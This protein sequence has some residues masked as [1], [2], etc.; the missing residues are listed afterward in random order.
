M[1]CYAVVLENSKVAGLLVGRN[2]FPF[3]NTDVTPSLIANCYA[4][5]KDYHTEEAIELVG[6]NKPDGVVLNSLWDAEKCGLSE[7]IE[8]GIPRSTAEM[9]DAQ[10]YLSQGWDFVGEQE[11]GVY[12]IWSMPETDG[13][14]ILA[15]VYMFEGRG[16][17]RDPYLVSTAV[18]L[19]AV[20]YNPQACY[21][22]ASSIDLAGIPWRSA[23]I[24][25]FAGRFYGNGHV[26]SNL[27]IR[28]TDS[29]KHYYDRDSVGLVGQLEWGAEILDLGVVDVNISAVGGNVG[30]LAGYSTGI[31]TN[32]YSTGIVRGG[33]CVGG[34]VGYNTGD[35]N[36]S[37]STTT[38]NARGDDTWPVGGLVGMNNGHIW[39]CYSTG[40]VETGEDTYWSA[41]GGL[42]GSN[43]IGTIA[44]SYSTGTVTGSDNNVGGLAGPNPGILAGGRRVVTHSFWDVET[45]GQLTSDGGIG[46]TTAEMQTAAIF[47]EA[48]WDFIDETENGTEDIWWI[49]EGQDYPR[50]WWELP[51]E[52]DSTEFGG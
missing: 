26:I 40:N 45:S 17:E 29:G 50:L 18:A 10:T 41:A 5:C 44:T 11:N 33:G 12:E 32:C 22:L 8:G 35:V 4:V 30:G 49:L 43:I 14:P 48:G 38:I 25:S 15:P 42:V 27:T 24:P 20:Q 23:P 36:T 37:Y 46:L 2:S 19:A 13:Y 51:Q 9:Q 28:G 34:L 6:S 7:D 47:L 21:S 39:S 31:I 52:E 16:T 3:W 1:D